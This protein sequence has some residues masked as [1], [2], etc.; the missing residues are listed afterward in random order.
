MNLNKCDTTYKLVIEGP[1]IN[2]NYKNYVF[3]PSRN[4]GTNSGASAHE[5]SLLKLDVW[6]LFELEGAKLWKLGDTIS[7]DR[8]GGGTEW[9]CCVTC[10]TRGCTTFIAARG[11]EI[12]RTGGCVVCRDWLLEEDDADDGLV[13]LNLRK[14]QK[15]LFESGDLW[16]TKKMSNCVVNMSFKSLRY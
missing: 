10:R 8:V 16:W 14:T 3:L 13:W 2:Y 9:G 11:C 12:C 15:K 6:T 1:D 5:V 7:T 4:R